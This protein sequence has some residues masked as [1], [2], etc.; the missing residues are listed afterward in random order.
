M[1]LTKCNECGAEISTDAKTCP[2]CGTSKPH[3]TNYKKMLLI[4]GVVLVLF[5][6]WDISKINGENKVDSKTSLTQA[7]SEGEKPLFT[8]H[9][10]RVYSSL[11]YNDLCILVDGGNSIIASEN[12]IT[13]TPIVISSKKLQTEYEKN[14]V[15][16][17]QK[18]K[19][20]QVSIKGTV[21]GI[22]KT[23]GD[24]I[25]LGLNGGSNMFIFPR[26]E[27]SKGYED[28]A[29]A[30]NK[31]DSIGLVCSVSG[32]SVGAAYL[33]DCIPSYIWADQTANS[34]I[35]STPEAVSNGNQFFTKLIDVSKKVSSK[36]KDNSNCFIDNQHDQCMDE[37][38]KVIN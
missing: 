24:S 14:E 25:M 18:F 36:L 7:S 5:T 9:E 30:L 23:F 28:W 12:I 33:K 15:A 38:N 37:I 26:A 31:G 6:I 3:K 35:A 1:A 10:L 16:A 32:M 11:L 34:I 8:D 2:H 20:K 22:D 19:G 29:A 4:G 27:I 17:D 21:K 13:P